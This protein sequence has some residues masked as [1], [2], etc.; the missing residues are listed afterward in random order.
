VGKVYGL[1]ICLSGLFTVLQ[2]ALD[3][4]THSVLEDDPRPVNVLLFLVALELVVV[5]LGLFGWGERRMK[6]EFLEVEA[7]GAAEVLMPCSDGD[8]D[9]KG[10]RRGYSGM[11]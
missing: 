7:E 9:G 11:K 4:S 2:S 1:I 10:D 8:R 3:A 6:R 5:W